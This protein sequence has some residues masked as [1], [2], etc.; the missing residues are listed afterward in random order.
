M[1]SK[2]MLVDDEQDI[3]ELLRYNI[4]R[5]GFQVISAFNGREA[6]EKMSEKPDMIILDVMMPEMDG[7]EVCRRIRENKLLCHIPIIFL[8]A[9]SAE[10]DEV[11]G[12]EMG[13]DDFVAKPISPKKLVA[14]IRANL[15][16]KDKPSVYGNESEPLL[17]LGPIEIDRQGF[18]VRIDGVAAHFLKKEFEILSLIAM[19]PGRVMRREVILNEIWGEESYITER[20]IDVHIRKIREKLGSHAE[21]IETIKGVGYRIKEYAGTAGA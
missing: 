18:E 14:R 19:K 1:K 21:M 9:K 5:E 4:E 6:L 16:W 2:I 15:R 11:M 20:T 13:A 7:Y 10:A 17:K 3:V 12:L 8:T